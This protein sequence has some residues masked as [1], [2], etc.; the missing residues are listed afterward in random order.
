MTLARVLI[1]FISETVS[2]NVISA[3]AVEPDILIPVGYGDFMKDREKGRYN[4]F[5]HKKG[6]PTICA[7]PVRLERYLEADM[8][9]KLE[10]LLERYQDKSP[11]V[12]IADADPQ[13]A[14]ALGSVL[15][16]HRYWKIS[17][18]DY[19]IREGIFLPLRGDAEL[20]RISFP[21]LYYEDYVFLKEEQ[22]PVVPDLTR[23]DLT[24]QAVSEIR[25]IGK[26]YAETPSY[27]QDLSARLKHAIGEIP[28]DKLDYIIDAASLGIRDTSLEELRDLQV[29]TFFERKNGIVRM[30]FADR[31]GLTLLTDISRLPITGIFLQ[32]ALVR[33]Y[34]RHAAYHDLMLLNGTYVAAICRCYPTI[35][36]L[37]DDSEGISQL[38]RFA[39]ET[40]T[41]YEE[42]VRRILVRY[43]N[44][45]WPKDFTE[46][47]G[48]YGIELVY[49]RDLSAK[50]EPR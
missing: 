25:A 39:A 23:R 48:H 27:W 46:A 29:L 20:R 1:K 21:R 11:V 33:E 24:R 32:T 15:M 9:V 42:P 6:I 41:L 4:H 22:N 44:T 5:F 13:M 30:R 17:V 8:E 43:S 49:I 10:R 2:G 45:P 7:D 14:M 36:A 26:L 40:F 35:I 16:K 12:D 28:P 18:L 3:L 34:G 31:L 50:L 47:A 38:A 19:R 37:M